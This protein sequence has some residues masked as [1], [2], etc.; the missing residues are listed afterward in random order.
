[1]RQPLE[2][3]VPTAQELETLDTVYRTTRGVTRCELFQSVKALLAAVADFFDRY[4]HE[5]QHT[6]S[7][8]GSKPAIVV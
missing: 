1:M 7:I 3:P 6:L 4:N 5:P 2:I 8:I